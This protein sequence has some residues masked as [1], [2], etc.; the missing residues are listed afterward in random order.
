MEYSN[1]PPLEQAEW[2]A[3]VERSVRAGVV[4]REAERIAAEAIEAGVRLLPAPD[5]VTMPGG[6][7]LELTD[8]AL[9]V[10]SSTEKVGKWFAS[11]HDGTWLNGWKSGEWSKWIGVEECIAKASGKVRSAIATLD[12]TGERK[13]SLTAERLAVTKMALSSG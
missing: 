9:R 3:F 2:K 13:A 11:R 7:L 8:S 1:M 6:T 12:A 5:S 10:S 4:E